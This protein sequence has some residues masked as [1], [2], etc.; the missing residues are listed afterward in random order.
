MSTD[1]DGAPPPEQPRRPRDEASRRRRRRTLA[2]RRAGVAAV[3][4]A[5]AATLALVLTG[6]SPAP[7]RAAHHAPRGQ[8]HV[9]AL[10]TAARVARILTYTSYIARGARRRDDVALTFDD[11]PSPD[12]RRILAILERAH[13]PATFFEV[14][15]NV[16]A[17]PRITA[18]LVRAR[19][20]VGDHTQ[21]HPPLARLRAAAQRAQLVDCARQ[22]V[23]AGAPFPT[24]FRPPYG[25][26]STTTL[27]V[28]RG[29]NMLMVLWSVDTGDYARPGVARIE[30]T[31]LSGA[32]GGGILL[33]H[34]GGGNRSQTIAALPSIIAQLKRRGV[35][36]VTVS[37]LLRDDP[38][39]RSQPPPRSLAGD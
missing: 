36:L 15:V 26:F 25:S 23:A 8:R 11:G 18:E 22:I 9:V 35:H 33:F 2:L 38:P 24:L 17:Y 34:D 4:A 14:G 30:Y 39:P 12:T 16:A 29:L 3:L 6:G 13:V 10:S 37:Q 20:E 27:G 19:M 21:N 32:R 1:D 31:A 28:A 5:I 7:A